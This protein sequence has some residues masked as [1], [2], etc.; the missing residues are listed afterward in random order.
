MSLAQVIYLQRVLHLHASE[1]GSGSW[2]RKVAA[3]LECSLQPDTGEITSA[4]MRQE[5]DIRLS[6][7]QGLRSPHTDESTSVNKWRSVSI[8]YLGS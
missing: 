6:R 3:R 2:P 1:V 7:D 5:V 8:V 4:G